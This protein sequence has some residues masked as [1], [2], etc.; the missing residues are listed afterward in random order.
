MH[1]NRCCAHAFA[2][3]EAKQDRGIAGIEPHAA[4]RR[5]PA[6]LRDVVGAV[7]G[8]AAVEEDRMGIGEL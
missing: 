2:L 8:I 6:E 1:Y 4:V 5:R 3:D 7:D